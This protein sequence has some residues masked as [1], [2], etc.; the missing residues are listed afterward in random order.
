MEH[1]VPEQDSK[2][3]GFPPTPLWVSLVSGGVA[4]T[5]T[6][7]AMFPLD[8][9]KTR[10]Q[11][12][13]TTS[14]IFRGLYQG[15][16]PAAI[17]SA[18]SAALFFGTYEFAKQYVPETPMGHGQAAV[19]GEVVSALFKVPFE[20]VKQRLQAASHKAPENAW[21]VVRTVYGREGVRG[22]YAGLGATLAR[23]IPFG[24]IQMPVYEFLKKMVRK[25][26]AELSTLQACGCG[27]VAGGLAAAATCPV[28]VWKTRLMLGDA[29]AS[30][31]SIWQKEGI[32]ALF[33][34]V[35]PRVI[36]ISVGGSVFFGAY[37]GM[38]SLLIRGTFIM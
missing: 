14:G 8:T 5:F 15:L 24:F 2:T 4:G 27:A 25:N 31:W 20:V 29:N 11:S 17:A 21:S 18:P 34:G 38:R 23:E 9:V 26:E 22:M 1:L 36:W 7:I 3:V 35:A 37:E 33:S 16:G 6:D 30:I 10:L 32:R 19:A 12:G 13:A 28:D